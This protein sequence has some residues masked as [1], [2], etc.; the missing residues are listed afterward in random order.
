[1]KLCFGVRQSKRATLFVSSFNES[2]IGWQKFQKS[3]GIGLVSGL[4]AQPPCNRALKVRVDLQSMKTLDVI[5]LP[6]EH[7]ISI[8]DKQ[9]IE[10]G[11]SD[12]VK[13]A[14]M[15]SNAEAWLQ[16]L[17]LDGPANP[18][19]EI[20][21][22]KAAEQFQVLAILVSR[23]NIRYGNPGVDFQSLKSLAQA[24]KRIFSRSNDV[25]LSE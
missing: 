15:T 3:L 14:T 24:A 4:L 21:F 8:K 5:S 7:T 6:F 12:L 2:A 16:W 20:A 11:V 9:N 18:R 17:E 10:D 13:T 19:S 22:T 1:L 23:G 25:P